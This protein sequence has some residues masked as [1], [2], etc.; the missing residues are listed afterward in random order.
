MMAGFL[1]P[2]CVQASILLAA[3]RGRRPQRRHDGAPWQAT[4]RD[5]EVASATLNMQWRGVVIDF[6][7]DWVE[8]CHRY[9]FPAWNHKM[10]PC[11]KCSCNVTEM[12]GDSLDDDFPFDERCHDETWYDEECTKREVWKALSDMRDVR[13][14]RLLLE[15]DKE[16]YRGRGIVADC[17]R[18][19]LRKG[20]RLEPTANLPDVGSIDTIGENDL[21]VLVCF[22]RDGDSPTQTYHRNPLIC[23]TAHLNIPLAS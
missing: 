1:T 20:D 9:G 7:G 16:K 8:I 5:R 6:C 17:P 15:Y 19:G 11:P 18:L 12:V 21:P 22:W 23:R 2:P 3:A 14:L 4:D 10:S 13:E